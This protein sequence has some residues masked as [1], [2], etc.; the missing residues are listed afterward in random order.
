[1][2][3]IIVFFNLK[4][5]VEPSD[6]EKWAQSTDL[7]IVRNLDSTKSFSVFRSSGLLGSDEKAPFQYVEIIEVGDMARFGEEVASETM[8]KVSSE[9]QEYADGPLF[10]TTESID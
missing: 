4:D 2:T 7:P 9:F 3:T 6:Y 5:G 1:M 10:L 8:Q